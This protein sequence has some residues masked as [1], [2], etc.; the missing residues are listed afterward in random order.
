MAEY[1]ESEKTYF[2]KIKKLEGGR[3]EQLIMKV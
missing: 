2:W 1:R 3:E